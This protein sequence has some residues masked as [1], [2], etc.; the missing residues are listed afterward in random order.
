MPD[1]IIVKCSCFV[2]PILDL[3]SE[4]IKTAFTSRCMSVIIPTGAEIWR[5]RLC[6]SSVD[7]S[8]ARHQY[9][10]FPHVFALPPMPRP[11]PAGQ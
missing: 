10:R 5:A 11:S 8:H 3:G 2:Q 6:E 9:R 1:E 7:L 4:R